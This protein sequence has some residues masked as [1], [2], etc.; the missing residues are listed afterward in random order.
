MNT[1]LSLLAATNGFLLVWLWW[2]LVY[3]TSLQIRSLYLYQL[4]K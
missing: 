3:P 1:L 2:V 4:L